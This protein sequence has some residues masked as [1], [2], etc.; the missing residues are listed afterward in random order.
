LTTFALLLGHT[1]FA[2]LLG[3]TA[4]PALTAHTCTH[5]PTKG[6]LTIIPSLIK[7]VG[8]GCVTSGL[9]SSILCASAVNS[10]QAHGLRLLRLSGLLSHIDLLSAFILQ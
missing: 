2:L 10:W 7:H 3:L 1:P 9:S 5:P 6:L 4:H 8:W